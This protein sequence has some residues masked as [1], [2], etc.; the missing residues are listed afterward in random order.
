MAGAQVLEQQLQPARHQQRVDQPRR[1]AQPPGAAQERQDD[2]RNRQQRGPQD[3]ER[4]ARD[5]SILASCQAGRDQRDGEFVEAEQQHDHPGRLHAA[6]ERA[7][8]APVRRHGEPAEDRRDGHHDQQRGGD[9]QSRV[10]AARPEQGAP[11]QS[12][13]PRRG[14]R[15]DQVDRRVQAQRLARPAAAGPR[16]RQRRGG[17]GQRQQRAAPERERPEQREGQGGGRVEDEA[18]PAPGDPVDERERRAVGRGRE[19]QPDEAGDRRGDARAMRHRER[20]PEPDHAGCRP[21]HDLA[22]EDGPA[23]APGPRDE[24]AEG[25][26]RQRQE[27]GDERSGADELRGLLGRGNEHGRR[28]QQQE[29]VENRDRGPPRALPAPPPPRGEGGR[30]EQEQHDGEQHDRPGRDGERHSGGGGAQGLDPRQVR[31]IA[32]MRDRQAEQRDQQD[33][34]RARRGR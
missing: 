10:R 15:G 32:A 29:T 30:R 11:R 14:R 21:L 17:E 7:P 26:D 22:G 23:G 31:E 18:A 2:R 8:G 34:R 4:R 5:L 25:E 27:Q 28:H 6:S 33:R 16:G 12:A 3:R 9:R 13:H 20:A 1:L 19:Q 24:R